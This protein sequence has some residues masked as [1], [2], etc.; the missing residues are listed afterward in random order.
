MHTINQAVLLSSKTVK[1]KKY[2]KKEF[3]GEEWFTSKAKSTYLRF[4][5]KNLHGVYHMRCTVKLAI[6]KKEESGCGKSG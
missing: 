5:R 1:K 3:A 2:Y 4:L 6:V